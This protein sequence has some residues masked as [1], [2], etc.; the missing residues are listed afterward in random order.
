MSLGGEGDVAREPLL[1]WRVVR[2]AGRG[3]AVK[4]GQKTVHIP[5]GS[6]RGALIAAEADGGWL[7]AKAAEPKYR[8]G[9]PVESD[10]APSRDNSASERDSVADKR[11][12]VAHE[13]DGVADKRDGVADR[14]EGVADDRDGLANRRE[15]LAGRREHEADIRE[16]DIDVSADDLR[17][18][19]VSDDEQRRR[20]LNRLE[21][22]RER[23]STGIDRRRAKQAR[24][25]AKDSRKEKDSERNDDHGQRPAE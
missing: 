3:A 8:S 16:E 23:L 17:S 9:M 4:G 7:L 5:F 21:D 1:E 2:R 10:G 20:I 18:P 14:R 6:D 11:D 25:E 12:G 15:A 22:H 13:R 19:A 24:D